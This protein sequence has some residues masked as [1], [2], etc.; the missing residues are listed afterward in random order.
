MAHGQGD[1]EGGA[2]LSSVSWEMGRLSPSSPGTQNQ[3]TRRGSSR[4]DLRQSLA[5]QAC[6]LQAPEELGQ[7]VCGMSSV[8]SCEHLGCASPLPLVLGGFLNQ[9]RF[10]FGW[11]VLNAFAV[12]CGTRDKRIV[13]KKKVVCECVESKTAC[14]V[15]L[16][17]ASPERIQ[18][19]TFQDVSTP[20]RK[21]LK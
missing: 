10:C 18:N 7:L 15:F 5:P 12:P 8:F 16:T 11:F 9:R 4:K 14:C 21:W 3:E 6:W 20:I 2:V 13:F 19:L 17:T 1:T